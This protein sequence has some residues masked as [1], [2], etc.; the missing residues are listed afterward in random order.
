M[1]QCSKKCIRGSPSEFPPDAR[2]LGPASAELTEVS[3]WRF[4]GDAQ[5]IA[6]LVAQPLNIVFNAPVRRIEQLD[7]GVKVVADGHTVRAGRAIV[8]IPPTL[9]GRIDYSPALPAGRDQL[10]QRLGQGTLTKVT[11]VYDTPFWRAQGLTG[12]SVSAPR[13]T[14]RIASGIG[15]SPRN[16]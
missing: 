10:T 13:P 11:A 2:T 5:R 4:Q 9:A 6:E 12:T 1:R 15:S 8:A 7:N 3:L 16:R 14:C